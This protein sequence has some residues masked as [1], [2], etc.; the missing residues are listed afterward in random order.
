MKRRS[1]EEWQRLI[2]QQLDSGLKASQF[3]KE[4]G[5]CEKYFST[6]KYKLKQKTASP[7]SFQRV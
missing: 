1:Q 5:L 4:H 7:N 6:V 3:C 2:Q